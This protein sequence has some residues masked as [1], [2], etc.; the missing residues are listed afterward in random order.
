MNLQMK[1][2]GVEVEAGRRGEDEGGGGG[3]REEEKK[4][5]DKMKSNKRAEW[6]SVW[7]SRGD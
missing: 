5:K 7:D 4:K 3:V 2:E 1:T 6:T